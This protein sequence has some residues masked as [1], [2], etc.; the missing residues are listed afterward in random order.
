MYEHY[1]RHRADNITDPVVR[2]Q[3]PISTIS[4]W[5]HHTQ[6]VPNGYHHDDQ[7]WENPGVAVQEVLN[8]N[9]K[10]EQVCNC[11]FNSPISEGSPASFTAKHEDS[12]GVSI[13]S[14]TSDLYSDVKVGK[15]SP[16]S[17]DSPLKSQ[18]TE[19]PRDSPIC[20][21]IHG[22]SPSLSSSPANMDDINKTAIIEEIVEEI[23]TKSEKMLEKKLAPVETNLI[24]PVVQD[25]EIVQAVIEVVST[26][27]ETDKQPEDIELVLK[28]GPH[29]S[30]QKSEDSEIPSPEKE[31]PDSDISERYL[32]PTEMVENV[33][34][35]DDE[36][37]E[38]SSTEP[39]SPVQDSNSKDPQN[40]DTARDAASDSHNAVPTAN[41]N[42]AVPVK[43]EPSNV[44]SSLDNLK[45]SESDK[46]TVPQVDSIPTISQICDPSHY[47]N[48]VEA[49]LN[50]NSGSL[51]QASTPLK[52]GEEPKRRVSLPTDGQ[53]LE[54]AKDGAV[55]QA[56]PQ[57]R[58]RS[59]ST[60]TQ[61]DPNHFGKF[62]VITYNMIF[63]II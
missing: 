39:T 8:D 47:D 61:I 15:D 16:F 50:E 2:Q 59:A 44:D 37:K 20:N 48:S 63:L 29:I 18:I 21:G 51:S 32:T 11:D 3:H 7:R 54:G 40:E 55:H 24:S 9:D 52:G 49:V 13:D 38:V 57:K 28:E 19:T 23:L 62:S 17:Q 12:E 26:V 60:S 53:T 5:D 42:G 46:E 14:R 30:P 27:V 10:S 33:E 58:P 1:E 4:G 56:S 41:E 25:E 6:T 43:L 45:T 34:K 31:V 35:V 36:A 22:S